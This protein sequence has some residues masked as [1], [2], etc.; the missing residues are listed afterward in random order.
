MA[1][2]SSASPSWG[3]ALVRWLLTGRTAPVPRA[4]RPPRKPRP[5]VSS[6]GRPLADAGKKANAYTGLCLLAAILGCCLGAFVWVTFQASFFLAR[7][8]WDAATA[9]LAALGMPFAAEAATVF[10]CA[11]GGLLIGWWGAHVGGLPEPFMQVIAKARVNGRYESAGLGPCAA[12]VILPQAFGGAVG[13]AAGLVGVVAVGCTFIG[14]SLRR[15]GLGIMELP[16][17]GATAV[18]RALARGTVDQ[19]RQQRSAARATDRDPFAY[20]FKRWAKAVLYSAATAAGIATFALLTLELGTQAVL[21]RFDVPALDTANLG[22]AV[23]CVLMGWAGIAIFQVSARICAR[24]DAARRSHALLVPFAGGVVLGLVGAAF[25]GV[26]FSGI[27]Q[28]PDLLADWPKLGAATLLA[29]GFCKFALCPLCIAT[30]WKGGQIYPCVFA[31][32]ACGLGFAA[33]TGADAALCLTATAATATACLLRSPALSFG[34]PLLCFPVESVPLLAA[35]CLVGAAL[36]V[37]A[38][39]SAQKK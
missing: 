10:L 34:L 15:A 36:P 19:A 5:L 14:A 21:P 13:L 28:T 7:V 4:P 8:F 38:A 18:A 24:F 3:K 12:G 9:G 6:A 35:A 16:R 11:A 22:W 20:D 32:V 1:R 27:A 30:G 17:R 25:P 29:T 23:P 2:N 37:P 31:A 26:M 33:L 39:S